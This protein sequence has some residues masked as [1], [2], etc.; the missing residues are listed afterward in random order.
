M[1]DSARRSGAFFLCQT[2]IDRVAR[3]S[4]GRVVNV[5]SMVDEVRRESPTDTGQV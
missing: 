4:N 1:T 2:A 3:R 5:T